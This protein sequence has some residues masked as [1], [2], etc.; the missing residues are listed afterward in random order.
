M[1]LEDII[2]LRRFERSESFHVRRD[3]LSL[4]RGLRNCISHNRILLETE[5]V[6]EIIALRDFLPGRYVKGFEKDIR[7]YTKDLSLNEKWTVIFVND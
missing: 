4:V 1:I 5:Y 6:S 3:D 7:G 2:I